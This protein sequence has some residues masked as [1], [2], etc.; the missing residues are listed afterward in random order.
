MISL[1]KILKDSHTFG[2][3]MDKDFVTK[4]IKIKIWNF[5]NA[6]RKIFRPEG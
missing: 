6:L 5:G 1:K 3:N 4:F 2:T